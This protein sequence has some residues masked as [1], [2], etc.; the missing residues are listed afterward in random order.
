VTDKVRKT[1][2]KRISDVT[3]S[4]E[5]LILAV[6]NKKSEQALK[7]MLVEQYVMLSV[8]LWESFVNDIFLAYALDNSSVAVG[9]LK[10][11]IG[12][13]VEGKFGAHAASCIRFSVRQPITKGRLALLLDP[14]N[15]NITV[16]SAEELSSKANELLHARS[17]KKFS[18]AKS[19]AQFLDFVVAF[20]NFLSHRSKGSRATMKE[21]LSR[22][23]EA[24]N[25]F[26]C[27]STKNVGGYL[28]YVCTG[29]N[30]R[31]VSFV[32]RLVTLAA[33]F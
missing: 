5:E 28:K 3:R 31:A 18:L 14:K 32:N 27:G 20:R 33:K 7:T 11:R 22:I 26:L 10:R 12:Q 23:T 19:D 15:W 30:S 2:C 25:K 16:R 4:H 1:F 6:H 13:S 8:V 24:D 21:A 29:G 9:N 17:A